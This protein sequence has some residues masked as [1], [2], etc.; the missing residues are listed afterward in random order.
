MAIFVCLTTQLAFTQLNVTGTVTDAENQPLIGVTVVVKNTANGTVTDVNGNYSISVPASPATLVYSYIGYS[1]VEREV[2]SSGAVNVSLEE[3]N[4]LLD[5]VVVSGLATNVK[6]SNLANAVDQITA[7]QLTSITQQS[8]V[9]GAIYAKFSG[10]QI[11]SSSGAPGGGM[12]IRI[13]GLTSINGPAQPLLIVD[14]IYIDNSS[15]PAGLNLVSQAAAGG[16]P[17]EFDQDNASNRLADIDP[18]DIESIEILKGA[19]AAAIYGSRAAGGVIIITTKKG[20]PSI[21]G[22]GLNIELQN[23]VGFTTILNR[24][25]T[26]DWTSEKVESIFGPDE[27]LVYEEAVSNGQIHDYEDELYGNTGLLYNTHLS[28][29]G[30]NDKTTFYAGFGNKDE[31]GIV[32]NTGYN[33]TNLRLNVNHKVNDKIDLFLSNYLLKTDADRGF[34]NNDNTGNT[35]GI[36]FASTPSWAQLQGDDDGNFP[37][38]PYGA[39]NFLQTAALATNNEANARYIGGAEATIRLWGNDKNSLKAILRG[40]TDIYNFRTFALFPRTLQFEQPGNGTDGASIQGSTFVNNFNLAGFLVHTYYG[41]SGISFTTSAGL[42]QESFDL[43]R[44]IISATQLIGSQTN[45]DQAGAVTTNQ[46]VTDQTDKGIFAQEEVNLKDMLILTAGVR[47]DKSSNNGDP[48]QL[49]YYPKASAALNIH[50]F[51]SWSST[52]WNQLKLRIAYGQSGNFAEFGSTFTALGPTSI[53]G[54]A[55]SLVSTLQG[56]D[57]VA[58]ERQ[59]ELEMG[60]DLAFFDYRLGL[61]ASYYIKTVED[62]LLEAQVPESSGFTSKVTNAMDMQNNG[63][64][65]ALTAEPVRTSKVNWYSRTSFWM[66]RSEVTRL[67]IPAFAVGAFG[68][69]LATYY[70]DTNASATQIV[71]IA[72]DSID[73]DADGVFDLAVDT[74]DDGLPDGLEVWGDSEPD[75]QMGFYNELT[76]GQLRLSFNIH[77][78]KGGDNINLSTLLTDIFGTSPDYD[79]TDLNPY[80]EADQL[81]NGEYRLANLGTSAAPWVEDASYVRLREVGLFYNFDGDKLVSSTN[82]ILRGVEIGLSG[83]NVLNFFD[84]N[85][86]DPEVSNFGV[87]G[88]STGVE[89]TPFPSSKRYFFHLNLSF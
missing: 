37:N 50:E 33:R 2:T 42:T 25:G 56:N 68:T 6:R 84:Y 82:G 77:W 85:S 52:D 45:V 51:S 26:R 71:G 87:N 20:K 1:T 44:T 29:S 24:L 22:E 34:F 76:F 78:K 89:V 11:T 7:K 53:G 73:T 4:S 57:A 65:L 43:N 66:N 74:K 35:M 12:G 54:S 40:G 8:T 15:I 13:R 23:S 41:T 61:E 10:A 72:P 32:A 16:N 30:G 5:A 17:A 28:L 14:G 75:F 83:Y 60:F 9:D 70:I 69:T 55:G 81:T 38:N 39:S 19:S 59:S 47:A 63:I 58:P 62:L 46:L 36:S 27:V 49:Y 31:G 48:N 3:T 67:D 88:I 79:D 86:Y 80:F 21:P 64:E 18:A